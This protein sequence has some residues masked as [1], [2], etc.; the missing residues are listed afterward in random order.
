MMPTLNQRADREGV[1]NEKPLSSSPPAK[2]FSSTDDNLW[3]VTRR[4]GGYCTKG[5]NRRDA[6]P[7]KA[8]FG[9]TARSGMR[10]QLERNDEHGGS[11]RQAR[12][13]DGDM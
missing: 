2:R 1:W 6:D 5:T 12:N 11:E 10:R 3:R 7:S 4:A 8:L 9:Y 13:G